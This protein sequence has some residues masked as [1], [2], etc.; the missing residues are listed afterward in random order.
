MGNQVDGSTGSRLNSIEHIDMATDAAANTLALELKDVM[1]MSG[2]NRFNMQN[3]WFNQFGGMIADT[4]RRHQVL[5]TGS[6]QDTLDIDLN[7]WSHGSNVASDGINDYNVWSHNSSAAQ[8][9]V[10]VGVNVI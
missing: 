6:A 8:L 2:M 10:L 9:L 5:I 1:D 7:Q 4:V 3:G